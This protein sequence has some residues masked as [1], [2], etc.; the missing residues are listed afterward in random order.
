M[1]SNADD[2][3]GLASLWD[4]DQEIR[5]AVLRSKSLLN[6]ENPKK[7]GHINNDSLQLNVQLLGVVVDHW[8]PKCFKAKTVPIDD[9]KLEV[10]VVQNKGI[11]E[12]V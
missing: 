8:C 9:I 3:S 1:T 12:L 11:N 10:G 6:W 5:H 4:S 7:T 2:L